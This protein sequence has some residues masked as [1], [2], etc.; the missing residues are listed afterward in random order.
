MTIDRVIIDDELA[1]EIE[2]SLEN[3]VLRVHEA[4]DILHHLSAHIQNGTVKDVQKN[5]RHKYK[6]DSKPTQQN[7]ILSF[8]P[9]H[10]KFTES[11]KLILDV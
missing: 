7:P 10:F 11:F 6:P 8:T 1:L 4:I 9:H 3:I 5:I 2:V